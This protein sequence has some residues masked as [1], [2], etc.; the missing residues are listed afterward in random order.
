MVKITANYFDREKNIYKGNIEKFDIVD[1]SDIFENYVKKYIKENNI[2]AEEDENFEDTVSDLYLDWLET[3]NDKLECKP[4][5]YFKPFNDSQL[6]QVLIK[7][8]MSHVKLPDPLIEEIVLRKENTANLI[9]KILEYEDNSHFSIDIK[10]TVMNILGEMQYPLPLKQYISFIDKGDNDDHLS[11]MAYEI[12]DEQIEQKDWHVIIEAYDKAPSK[13]A[14]NTYLDILARFYGDDQ[15]YERLINAFIS[16][17]DSD[18]VAFYAACIAKFG[19]ERAVPILENAIKEND[20]DYLNFTA[21]KYAIEQLGDEIN[22]D[23]IFDGDAAYEL[24]K[25]TRNED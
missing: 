19:D 5:E 22:I 21:I 4:N 9:I 1:F 12:I 8:V 17:I 15:A 10:L 2:D 23:K 3:Y 13:Y 18:G 20:Y 25:N 24:L 6:I 7:Y 16:N 11:Q 14:K